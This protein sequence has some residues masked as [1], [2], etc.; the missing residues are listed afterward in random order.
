MTTILVPYHL[1][2]HLPELD[3]PLVPDQ[4]IT[5]DPLPDGDACTVWRPL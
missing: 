3:V 1:D 2:E 4:V 5:A